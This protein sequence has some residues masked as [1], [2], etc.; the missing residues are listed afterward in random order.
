MEDRFEKIFFMGEDRKHFCNLKVIS[1][2]GLPAYI[3]SSVFRIG[4]AKENTFYCQVNF[5]CPTQFPLSSTHKSKFC[6]CRTCKNT[7]FW[8]N[9]MSIRQKGKNVLC[10]HF[11]FKKTILVWTSNSVKFVDSKPSN[12]GGINTISIMGHPSRNNNGTK[13]GFA[14]FRRRAHN[15]ISAQIFFRSPSRSLFAVKHC[16]LFGHRIGG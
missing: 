3:N 10:Q 8:Y 2:G 4:F 6:N 9:S 7:Y 11:I 5:F 14:H 13:S 15:N 1:F 16:P 12:L